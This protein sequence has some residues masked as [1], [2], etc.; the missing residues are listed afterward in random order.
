MAPADDPYFRQ[1]SAFIESVGHG[2]EPPVTAM[3]GLRAVAI[4][5]AAIESVKPETRLNLHKDKLPKNHRQ[6][7]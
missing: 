3:D 7:V 1:L 5:E 2:T 4:A 6:T